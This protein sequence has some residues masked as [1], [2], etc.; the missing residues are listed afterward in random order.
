MTTKARKILESNDWTIAYASQSGEEGVRVY[1]KVA[2]DAHGFSKITVLSYHS[3]YPYQSHKVWVFADGPKRIFRK[4]IEREISFLENY[5]DGD[6]VPD[7]GDGIRAFE[8]MV[9]RIVG[10]SGSDVLDAAKDPDVEDEA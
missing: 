8:A 1:G 5:R 9:E 10:V 6:P 7:D 4:T 3:L 2:D